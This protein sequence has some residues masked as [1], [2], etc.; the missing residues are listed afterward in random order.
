MTPF[1][2]AYWHKVFANIGEWQKSEIFKRSQQYIFVP[3]GLAK[4]GDI[5]THSS[6]CHKTLTIL[7]SSVLVV[8]SMI[9]Y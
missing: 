2:L 5:K 4:V 9:G 1:I 6:V 8:V 7:I 3:R